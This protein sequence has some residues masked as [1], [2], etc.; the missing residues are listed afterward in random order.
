MRTMNRYASL[1][2]GGCSFVDGGKKPDLEAYDHMY[3]GARNRCDNVMAILEKLDE[4]EMELEISLPL[5]AE[6]GE[7]TCV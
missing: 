6:G 7:S 4:L 2:W 1:Q 3:M 5:I